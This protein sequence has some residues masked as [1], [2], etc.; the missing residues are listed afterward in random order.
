MTIF[1]DVNSGTLLEICR[2]FKATC[3]STANWEGANTS[4]V[5]V[6]FTRIKT[7]VAQAMTVSKCKVQAGTGFEPQ[8]NKEISCHS[9]YTIYIRMIEGCHSNATLE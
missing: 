2:R 9:K 6:F 1:C 4:E 8:Y 3:Y 7:A 5:S